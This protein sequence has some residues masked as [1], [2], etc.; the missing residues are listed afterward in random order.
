MSSRKTLEVNYT[1]SEELKPAA[2][3][4]TARKQKTFKSITREHVQQAL[5]MFLMATSMINDDEE[6][7]YFGSGDHIGTFHFR[8]EKL[9][10]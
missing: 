7:T 1:D 9:N 2:E 8:T 5:T 10:D 6:V 4:T 3:T